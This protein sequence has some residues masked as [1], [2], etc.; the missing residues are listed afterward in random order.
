LL[1]TRALALGFV[2]FVDPFGLSKPTGSPPTASD[3]AVHRRA[4]CARFRRPSQTNLTRMRCA[5]GA[6]GRRPPRAMVPWRASR[7][8]NALGCTVAL[9]VHNTALRSWLALAKTGR[10]TGLGSPLSHLRRDWAHPCHICAG[11]GLTP[12]T[13]PPGPGSPLPRLHRDCAHPRRIC[14]GTRRTPATSAPGLD[15]R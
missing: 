12:A 9:R 6:D 3:T 8:Q 5:N 10:I 7:G 2:Y 15:D 11:T 13:P 4:P 1:C 14:T